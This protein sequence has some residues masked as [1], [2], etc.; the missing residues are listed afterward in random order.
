M[1]GFTIVLGCSLTLTGFAQ[2]SAQIPIAGDRCGARDDYKS[3]QKE[4]AA[5]LRWSLYALSELR[6]SEAAEDQSLHRMIETLT[7]ES[8]FSLANIYAL[9][10]MAVQDCAAVGHEMALNQRFISLLMVRLSAPDFPPTLRLNQSNRLNSISGPKYLLEEGS[11]V[12]FN[13]E[14]FDRL[15]MLRQKATPHYNEPPLGQ[16]TTVPLPINGGQQAPAASRDDPQ[17]IPIWLAVTDLLGERTEPNESS[18]R[19]SVIPVD[20]TGVLA[21]GSS[22]N[23]LASVLKSD[24]KTSLRLLSTYYRH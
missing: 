22:A 10:A 17:S 21:S 16:S 19:A 11:Q 23:A 9:R 1:R 15:S 8:V 18:I 3:A 12:S 4:N 2:P 5:D 7:D 13:R 20:A 6:S 14:I 24:W